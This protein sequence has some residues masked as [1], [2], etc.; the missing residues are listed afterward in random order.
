MISSK[1]LKNE[2]GLTLIEV[3]VSI[4][5]LSIITITF[6]SFFN[7]A[8]SYTKKNEDKTVGINV[9]R[10]VLY[11]M[12]QQEFQPFYDQYVKDLLTTSDIAELTIDSCSDVT[13][14]PTPE[15][16]FDESVC[17]GYLS[18]TI[19]NR[20]FNTKIFLQKHE[21]PSLQNYLIPVEIVVT[22]D[23][24]EATVRGFIKNE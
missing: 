19:N 1:F 17:R 2:K 3:L 18:S 5:L 6:L 8:Y 22:W 7:Q 4:T 23:N 16:I 14:E 9:A 24:Q 13:A 10:N 11:Y 15:P 12:E 20:N 21:D